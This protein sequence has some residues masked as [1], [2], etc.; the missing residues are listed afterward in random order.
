MASVEEQRGITDQLAI[1][2]KNA[3]K[4]HNDQYNEQDEYIESL[5]EHLDR[6]EQTIEAQEQY[7]TSLEQQI[8]DLQNQVKTLTTQSKKRG[9]F[10]M[11]GFGNEENKPPQDSKGK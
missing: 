5:E 8:E 6:H 7:I 2:V 4:V 11:I 10:Q 3:D 9:Y 1:Q